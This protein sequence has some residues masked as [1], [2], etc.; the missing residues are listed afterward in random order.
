M[1]RHMFL[2]PRRVDTV[3]S[4]TKG[5]TVLP[6]AFCILSGLQVLVDPAEVKEKNRVTLTCSTN[7]SLSNNPTYI[8]YKNSQPVTG[9]H[10]ATDNTLTIRSI[11]NEDTGFYS[12]AVRDEVQE[13]FWFIKGT[14]TDLKANLHYKGRVTYIGNTS[15]HTLSIRGLNLSD[16]KDYA[17]R[18]ITKEEGGWSGVYVPLRVTGLQVLV[19]P[20]TVNEGDRVT[21]TCS[22]T[23]SLSNNPTY[24]WYRNS[25]PVSNQHTGDYRLHPVS[26]EDAGK[27]SCAVEG[28]ES[29][30]SPERPLNVTYHPKNTTASV[31]PSDEVVE[32]ESVSLTC[33]SD[34]NPPVQNY[35]WYSHRQGAMSAQ[36]G[37][38]QS[39][40]I[41]NVRAEHS[42][43]YYCTA[44]NKH[45]ASNSSAM[46]LNVLYSPRNIS[47]SPLSDLKDSVTLTCRS[48]ANPAAHGYTWY[49]ETDDGTVVQGTG[50]SLSL[51]AGLSGLYHCEA[52]NQ[53][54]SRNST[55]VWVFLA[56]VFENATTTLANIALATTTLA[57]IALATTTLA[58]IALANIALATT[59][60]ANIALATTT[61]ANTTLAN[62]ALANTTLANIAL[63]TTTLAN[64]SLATTT[65]ATI[66]LANIALANTTLA[67]I[68]LANIALA[69]TTLANIALANTTLANIALA[70][71]TLA[72]TTLANTTLANTTLANIALAN[73]TLA[74]IALAT[75][76][77]ATTTLANTSLA[78]TT[79]ATTTLANIALA[80]TTLANIA[81]AN[82]ALATTTLANTTL[83]NI[84]L[85]NIALA[86]TT[87]ATTTLANIA[88][89]T[90]TLAPTT[91]ANIA[92][93]TTTL[94]TTTLATTT[95]AN[96]A[97][98]TTTLANIALANTTLAN[99]TL[100]NIALATIALANTTLANTTLAN[101]A[102]ANTTLANIALATTTLATTT[103]ANTTLAN[104]TLANIA[105]A[106]IALANTTLANIALATTT[107]ATT[108]LANIALATTTLATTTLANIALA[109]TTLA[110]T[111]LANIA[112]A[113]TTLANIALA[114]IALATTTL[115]NIALAN[116]DDGRTLKRI[117]SLG[118]GAGNS[119]PVYANIPTTKPMVSAT[120]KKGMAHTK[121]NG[122]ANDGIQ[123]TSIRFKTNKTH[124]PPTRSPILEGG[125]QYASVQFRRSEPQPATSEHSL[126]ETQH[127]TAMQQGLSAVT[128]AEGECDIYSKVNKNP[129]P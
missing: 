127:S 9:K 101:I 45:G 63:A 59:T 68:A 118:Q 73:T 81:L 95:L 99:T 82:I 61:L 74:N 52:Q 26:P 90:T 30:I 108:T 56:V 103:L 69:T 129:K 87:L 98:A 50:M 80:K 46:L 64:T 40:N 42:G 65:L 7:C 39:Y 111:T 62:I 34:A 119:N 18:F 44:E 49:R 107:L 20:A 78:T 89:A 125:V 10:T 19:D 25:Q 43:H 113:N 114:N 124:R 33:H 36:L 11:T 13:T 85:A 23:C 117:C 2:F 121:D 29:L 92:V 72:T 128:Q 54:G 96:I 77:L 88:L 28:H 93:A 32:G 123:Y 86:N 21:L 109:N 91:L 122:D 66:T 38:G 104:T 100:A 112:L 35:T 94:A 17:F 60:L 51:A 97:L 24:I 126:K 15:N 116:I 48:D 6:T 47:V 12:C 8:W 55:A 58:N 110:T 22:T 5:P 105:L 84:A 71:T 27:Y 106:T 115:A 70:T 83:A 37:E 67:N 76:T 16:S 102:L 41:S 120:E 4:F 14:N 1:T 75:T 53:V 57:N 31:H 3:M 79:L